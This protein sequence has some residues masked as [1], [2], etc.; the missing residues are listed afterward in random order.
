MRTEL[1][2]TAICAMKSSRYQT[3]GFMDNTM[4]KVTA[5]ILALA[6]LALNLYAIFTAAT[7]NISLP[8]VVYQLAGVAFILLA[9]FVNQAIEQ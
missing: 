8:V 1:Q 5:G 9:L 2:Q 7:G 6:G 4:L 3:G